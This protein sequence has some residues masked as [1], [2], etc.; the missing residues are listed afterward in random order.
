MSAVLFAIIALVGW[1]T[2]DIFGGLVARKVGGYSSAVL[3][4]I[5]CV[6]ITSFYIPF[7]LP[8]LINFN[9]ESIL[10]LIVLLPIGIIPLITLYEGINRGNASLVGIISGSF[11]ALV[12]ILSVIFLKESLN[13]YQIVSIIVVFVGL[14]LSSLNLKN[15][16]LKQILTDKGIPFALFSLVAWA[17]HLT[18]IKIPIRQVG[19]FWPAYISWWG[20]PLVFFYLKKKS[21]K[22]SI[23][24][25]KKHRIYMVMNSMISIIAIFSFNIAV[26]KGQSSIVAPIASSYPALF[27]LLAYF[28]FK[29]KLTKQQIIGMFTTLIG[30]ILLSVSA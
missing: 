23:P 7:A 17:I 29:D 22:I 6:I 25:D 21:I 30:I 19:W 20:F 2:A 18:F 12:A 3:N 5:L 28:V 15:F 11:G 26:A 10:W 13:V 27:A 8:E 14:V 9:L 16:K 4:Y 1:G 24:S